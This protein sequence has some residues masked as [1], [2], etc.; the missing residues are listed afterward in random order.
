MTADRGIAGTSGRDLAPSKRPTTTEP[1]PGAPAAI[2]VVGLTKRFGR[3]VAVDDL[4]MTVPA[5]VIAGFVGPNGAGKTTTM[6]MLLGLVTANAGTGTVLGQP[7]DEPRRYLPRVGAL[8]ESPAFYPSLSGRQNLYF[9]ARLGGIDLGRVDDALSIV[10][11]MGRGDDAYRTYS[12]GMKQRLGIAAALLPQPDLLLLDEPANGL[13]PAG[14][15]GIRELLVSLAQG[16]TTILVSSHLLAE[17]EALCSWM[18]LV[19]RGRRV[20][21]GAVEGLGGDGR[22]RL[23]VRTVDRVHLSLVEG[24]AADHGYAATR[25]GD[26]IVIDG[27][28]HFAGTLNTETMRRG[29]VICELAVHTANLEERFFAMTEEEM[30]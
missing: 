6:R 11:L 25:D 26:R 8:I 9:L 5:G 28:V 3:H 21:Q 20:Y 17:V 7:L 18:I 10:G 22:G 24:V 12:L 16:G 19:H 1:G 29:G 15:R 23:V 14:I 27:P 30:P 4:S 13:D 2:D